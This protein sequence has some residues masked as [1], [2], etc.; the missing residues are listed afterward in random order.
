MPCLVANC[1][2]AGIPFSKNPEFDNQV[3][4]EGPDM[5]FYIYHYTTLYCNKVKEELKRIGAWDRRRI[6]CACVWFALYCWVFVSWS[7]VVEVA[8]AVMPLPMYFL[9]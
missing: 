2:T 4:P 8:L 7:A 5:V 9:V 3:L 6:V 1:L